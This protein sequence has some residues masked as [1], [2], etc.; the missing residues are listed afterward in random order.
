[1]MNDGESPAMEQPDDEVPPPSTTPP[2]AQAGARHRPPT[3]R[4]VPKL[5]PGLVWSD[6][7]REMEEEHAARLARWAAEGVVPLRTGRGGPGDPAEGI[8]EAA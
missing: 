2:A 8:E 6:L 3:D 1:M 7:V 5:E 4:S